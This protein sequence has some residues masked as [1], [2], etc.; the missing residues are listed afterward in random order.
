MESW[1]QLPAA[2]RLNNSNKHNLHNFVRKIGDIFKKIPV[3]IR[4]RTAKEREFER[5][6]KGKK[7]VLR[8]VHLLMVCVGQGR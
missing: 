1:R 8:R 3:L 4:N 6:K 2:C 5:K 7:S